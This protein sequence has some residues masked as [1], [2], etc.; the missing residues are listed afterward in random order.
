MRMAVVGTGYVG[1]VAGAGFANLGNTVRGVDRDAKKIETLQAGRIPI[2]EPGLEDLVARNVAARRLS[3]STDVEGAARDSEVVLVAVG[4][5]SGP[6]GRADLSAVLD[7]ADLVGTTIRAYTV[8]LIKSTVPVGTNDRVTERIAARTKVPFDVV[9]NP[10]FLKEGAAVADFMKP[11]RVVIGART[12]RA[13]E[14]VRRLYLPLMQTAERILVMDPRSAELTKYVANSYL[15][16][17]ISFINE[18]A[19]LCERVGADASA[20]RAG[21]GSDSRIGLRYFFPGC[22]YGGSCFPK[23]VRELLGMAE[24]NGMPLQILGAVHRVNEVQKALLARKVLARFGADLT[25]KRLAV[26]GLA[27]KPETDDMREA[28]SLA[29][30]P[31]LL[32]AGAEVRAHDPVARD[33]ARAHLPPSVLLADDEYEAARGADALLVCTEWQGYRTP[34]FERLRA[35]MRQP[36]VFDGRNVWARCSL[37]ELGFEYY[38]IGA[39]KALPA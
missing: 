9:S 39:G 2:F 33:A 3:F 34:D 21:A 18:I 12:E 4:T 36:V 15:A 14:L 19:N 29:V 26:W 17:R 31:A 30:I 35:A 27:F 5:P 22:G 24:Q 28:P 20:V 11:D 1:L 38:G 23:D 7:V 6:D 25:G 32:E 37:G 13:R 8:V 16:T 10:E